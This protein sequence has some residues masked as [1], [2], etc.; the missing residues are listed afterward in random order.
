MSEWRTHCEEHNRTSNLLDPDHFKPSEK[1][2]CFDKLF[3]RIKDHSNV[4]SLYEL[5]FKTRIISQQKKLYSQAVI[6]YFK[7]RKLGDAQQ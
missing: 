3:N 2:R 6:K 5:F 4:L 7:G 1:H